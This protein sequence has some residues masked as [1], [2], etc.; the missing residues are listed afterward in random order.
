MMAQTHARPWVHAVFQPRT[1]SRSYGPKSVPNL[2]ATKP[3]HNPDKPTSSDERRPE[4]RKITTARGTTGSKGAMRV[5]RTHTSDTRNRELLR[6]DLFQAP[7]APPYSR[8]Q[9]FHE[10]ETCS[11]RAP[12]SSRRRWPARG[13]SR[14]AQGGRPERQQGCPLPLA[15]LARDAP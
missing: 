2:F 15:C 11:P 7:K 4:P 6:F 5:R 12:G 13:P 14:V 8:Q 10:P 9:V 3:L 1:A